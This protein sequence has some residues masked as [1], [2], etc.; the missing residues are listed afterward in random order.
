MTRYLVRQTLVSIIK[1]FVFVTLMFFL[2]QIVMPGDFVDQFSMSCNAECRAEMRAQLGLDLPIWQRYLQWLRQIISGD[3]GRSL[4]QASIIELL[5]QLV[6]TTLL[7]FLTGTVLAFLIGLLLGKFAAWRGSGFLSSTTTFGSIVLFTSFPPWLAWLLA[8]ALQRQKTV[9]RAAFGFRA[10][11]FPDI[12]RD[13]WKAAEV[14][15][16]DVAA[17]MVASIVVASL[18]VLLVVALFERLTKLRIPAIIQILIIIGSIY[19]YWYLMGYS[20]YALDLLQAGSLAIIAYTLLSFGETMLIMRSSMTE[21]LKEEYVTAAKA[22][23]LPPRYIRDKHAARNAILPVLSRLVISLPYLLTGIVI[24]EDA[25]N[26]PGMGTGMMN[27]LYWQDMPVVMAV[28]LIVGGLSLIARLLLDILTAYLD[29]RIRYAQA[30][31]T[32]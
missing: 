22:K 4:H 18:A 30:G 14:E 20:A 17:K 27:S 13:L 23:G 9:A 8:Y 28:M 6:P 12:T 1:L 31:P 5:R 29:P 25:L 11:T 2:I 26:W 24:V 19:L 16:Y 3:L 32:T 21:V 7:I 15:P 10:M